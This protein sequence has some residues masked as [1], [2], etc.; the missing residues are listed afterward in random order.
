MLLTAAYSRI[1]M[2]A[3]VS[4][5][6]DYKR[7]SPAQ[8]SACI[9]TLILIVSNVL[10]APDD[11]AKRSVCLYMADWADSDDVRMFVHGGVI[12]YPLDKS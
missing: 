9:Q 10:D 4:H 8:A 12:G 1:F 2:L 5:V 11:T 3:Q 7:N 6:L